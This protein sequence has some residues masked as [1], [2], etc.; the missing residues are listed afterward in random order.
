MKEF[1]I[2][3]LD[4]QNATLRLDS[5][6]S[7]ALS[8]S[9]NQISHAI[10]ANKVFVND[11][12]C[13][14]NGFALKLNDIVKIDLD[15]IN[16]SVDSSD[17]M[18]EYEIDYDDEKFNIEIIHNDND[19]MIINKPP[20]LVTHHAQSVKEATLTHW[21]K[22]KQMQ[23]NTLSNQYRFGIVHRLDKQTSG[24]LAIAKNLDSMQN[25]ANQLKSKQMGRYY[26]AI[27]D[28]PLKENMT[29]EGFMCRNQ[30]NRL[31]MSL[32]NQQNIQYA[33][34]NQS[35]IYVK[36]GA[37]F[38][39]S[40]FVKLALLNNETELIAIKLFT[41]RTHQIRTHLESIN[42]HILGDTL[43]G[44]RIDSK[45][46]EGRILLH[47]YLL[48]LQHPANN[49]KQLYKANIFADMLEYLQNHFTI[50]IS[51]DNDESSLEK[52]LQENYIINR[53][54]SFI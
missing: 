21:L 28:K 40:A 32:L 23:L 22:D 11:K 52:L 16:F 27:I 18:G 20:H 49:Q 45:K 7:K 53:F 33:T 30:A 39:K 37:R 5:Y 34:Q 54:S 12:L 9:K 26:L 29:I 1:I 2:T 51:K 42:R 24:A 38:S 44:Y 6:L 25:L 17:F 19:L 48:Y 3:T 50:G 35:S 13:T 47:S 10:K 8:T 14:K 4:L 15:S 41:G 31:K 36:K 43:Y 46:Y